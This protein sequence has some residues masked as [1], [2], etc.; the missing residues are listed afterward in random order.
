MG[1]EGLAIID[2]VKSAKL[3]GTVE[4]ISDDHFIWDIGGLF[5]RFL[6]DDGETTVVYSKKKNQLFDIGHFHED[7]CDD[8][9]LIQ[10]INDENNRIHIT[11]SF[12]SS[13][14]IEHKTNKKKKNWLIVRHYYSEL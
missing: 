7:N 8:L 5:L 3:K 2:Y 10:N 4:I 13:F 6:I 14:C 1:D 11:V 12:V 9:N